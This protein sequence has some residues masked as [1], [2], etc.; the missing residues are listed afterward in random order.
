MLAHV[1]P[2][3][4][5]EAQRKHLKQQWVNASRLHADIQCPRIRR[6]L[7]SRIRDLHDEWAA[8]DR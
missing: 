7:E 2:S 8:I 3:P 5:R 4:R 6:V 1:H